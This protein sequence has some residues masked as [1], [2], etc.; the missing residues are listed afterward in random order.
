MTHSRYIVVVECDTDSEWDLTPT[1]FDNFRAAIHFAIGIAKSWEGCK[2]S[3]G[4]RIKGDDISG[5]LWTVDGL[6]TVARM[7]DQYD[8][9]DESLG[10]PI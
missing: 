2:S 10:S 5:D 7:I 4:L 3:P 9:D 1:A 6:L 8:F